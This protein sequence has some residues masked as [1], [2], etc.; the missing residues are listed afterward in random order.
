MRMKLAS[1][2]AWGIGAIIVLLSALFA[3]LQNF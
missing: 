1:Y 2:L 3:F